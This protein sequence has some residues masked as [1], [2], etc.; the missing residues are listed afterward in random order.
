MTTMSGTTVVVDAPKPKRSRRGRRSDKSKPRMVAKNLVAA[1]APTVAGSAPKPISKDR[2]N[3]MVKKKHADHA[4]VFDLR[5]PS[6]RY[7]A[8]Y[9][10]SVYGVKTCNAA[11]YPELAPFPTCTD[12][13]IWQVD[14]PVVTQAVTGAKYCI[15]AGFPTVLGTVLSASAI[16]ASGSIGYTTVFSHPDYT[17][18]A[19]DWFRYRP[20]GFRLAIDSFE[21]VL[22]AAGR[23]KKGLIVCT[24][25]GN[26]LPNSLTQANAV[27]NLNITPIAGDDVNDRT[28]SIWIPAG[29]EATWW[30]N[31]TTA[32]GSG[33]FS[34][35]STYNAL[36]YFISL[37]AGY[38]TSTVSVQ[39]IMNLEGLPYGSTQSMYDCRSCCGDPGLVGQ[40]LAYCDEGWDPTSLNGPAD[41]SWSGLWEGIKSGVG[42]AL[43]IAEDVVGTVQRVAG[44]AGTFLKYVTPFVGGIGSRDPVLR[45]RHLNEVSDLLDEWDSITADT[46]TDYFS[47]DLKAFSEFVSPCIRPN[48][49][50]SDLKEMAHADEPPSAESAVDVPDIALPPPP[51]V[52]KQEASSLSRRIEA[53]RYTNPSSSVL[54]AM[55]AAMSGYSAPH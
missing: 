42:K 26:I 52:N 7:A 55:G 54:R 24:A 44:T 28:S 32:G 45:R 43:G 25:S 21:S 3:H 40:M 1:T 39:V 51:V 8:A 22:N 12:R 23:V 9:L 49:I 50:F 13:T 34:D 18:I 53:Y 33:V 35:F 48:P 17:E 31:P 46:K 5:N 11:P 4:P 37:P 29:D 38:S 14:V 19:N 16:D 15:F 20:C 47:R 6:V 41:F 2:T 10:F 27:P 36:F 30:K